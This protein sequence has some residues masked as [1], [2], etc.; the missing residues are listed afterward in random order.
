VGALTR[1]SRHPHAVG[2]RLTLPVYIHNAP[3]VS[4]EGTLVT[5]VAVSLVAVVFAYVAW[6]AWR[7]HETV[8]PPWA[9]SQFHRRMGRGHPKRSEKLH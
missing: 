8:N 4:K 3:Q 7:K 6:R 2:T 1:S 5:F 9:M